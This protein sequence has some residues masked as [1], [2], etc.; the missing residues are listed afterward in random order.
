ME[1]RRHCATCRR[2]LTKDSFSGNQWSKAVGISRC[3]ACVHGGSGSKR[4]ADDGF[5]VEK[6]ARTARRNNAHRAEFPQHALDYPFAS[7]G[8]R[9]VAKGVYTEGERQG[10]PCVCKWF[11]SGGVFETKFYDTDIKN[12]GKAL[13]LLEEFNSQN[14]VSQEVRLNIPEVWTF[15]EDSG[16]GWAHRKVLQ[17]PF[18]EGYRKFNSNSG[19]ADDATP[20][21]RVM[22]ALSH[23]SYHAS[24]GQFVLCDLQGGVTHTGVVLTDPAILSR[25]KQF[26]VTDLGP[27][28]ISTFFSQ[29]TCN[30]FC[31]DHWS[32]PV[33]R[34]RYHA[35]TMGTSMVM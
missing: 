16:P 1:R 20:W 30:E 25:R 6:R 19:W 32:K 24:G 34:H 28:G 21:P 15:D 11:K 33:D 17:E 9:Y 4:S 2:S 10:E 12:V 18:I 26:G 31:Q 13:H 22:Q 23:F 35:V 5:S 14:I 7:G 27:T 3:N 29:H 8:F